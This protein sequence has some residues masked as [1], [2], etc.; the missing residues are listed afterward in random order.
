MALWWW[1]RTHYAQSL[2][3]D[4]IEG[5]GEVT[6]ERLVKNDVNLLLGWDAV[7][8][9]LEEFDGSGGFE[10]GHGDRMA[11]LLRDPRCKVIPPAAQQDLCNAK[12]NYVKAC[13]S[14]NAPTAPTVANAVVSAHTVAHG[15][16]RQRAGPRGPRW[17]ATGGAAGALRDKPGVRT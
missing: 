5:P 6:R 17:P 2:E 12:G 4:L 14:Q 13:A 11:A 15:S 9:H 8:A 1:A 7:S 10:A 3:C 16:R